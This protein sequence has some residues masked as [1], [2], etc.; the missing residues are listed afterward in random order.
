MLNLF[1]V[2]CAGFNTVL[3]P[4]RPTLLA[5][6]AFIQAW[7]WRVALVGR[8]PDMLRAA[9][10]GSLVCATLTFMPEALFLWVHR[11]R[12]QD[13]PSSAPTCRLRVSGM[14][15]TACTVK[16]KSALEALEGVRDCQVA[17]Q[18]GIVTLDLDG[19]SALGSADLERT[20]ER[21]REAV[22]VAGFEAQPLRA[23]YKAEPKA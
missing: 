15:C 6:T 16:V 21:A 14:G 1:S 19:T 5:L 4:A 9:V 23:A 18:T 2:G 22:E 11:R 17:F 13:A 12:L 20:E 8:A 10:S 3:G 7:V